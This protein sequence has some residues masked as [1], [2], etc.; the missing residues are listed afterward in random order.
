MVED[1][2]SR[3]QGGRFVAA[4]SKAV[5]D[6]S[7]HR[8]GQRR[9]LRLTLPVALPKN[10]VASSLW[11]TTLRTTHYTVDELVRFGLSLPSSPN[12]PNSY[13]VGE[14][15]TKGREAWF[16][17]CVGARASWSP[18]DMDG[19]RGKSEPFAVNSEKWASWRASSSF[20]ACNQS[21]RRDSSGSAGP[22]RVRSRNLAVQESF[23]PVQAAIAFLANLIHLDDDSLGELP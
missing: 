3:R 14:H 7:L 9:R 8:N 4:R 16:S 13:T 6:V 20:Y 15:A 1:A 10:V 11:M 2:L 22:A 18:E 19:A 23:T 17:E 12:V 21:F 5:E